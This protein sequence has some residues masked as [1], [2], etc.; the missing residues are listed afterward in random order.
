L[1]GRFEV[2]ES[3]SALGLASASLRLPAGNPFSPF[4]SDVLL[5]RYLNPADPLGREFDSKLAHIG[6][7]LGGRMGAWLW[8]LTGNYDRL[9]TETLTDPGVDVP[10]LQ[11]RLNAGDPGRNPFSDAAYDLRSRD[12]ARSVDSFANTELVFSGTLAKLPAGD[13]SSSFRAGF[14]AAISAANPCAAGSNNPPIFRG[15]VARCRRTSIFRSPADAKACSLRSETSRPTSTSKS[16]N[17][18]TSAL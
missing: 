3:R 11:A 8:S 7:A 13:L 1:N 10:A 4:G 14:E 2:N 17:C 15:T 5:Y 12:E 9:S 16:R 6:A 18:R